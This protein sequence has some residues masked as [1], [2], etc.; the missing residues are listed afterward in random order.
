[1]EGLLRNTSELNDITT[2]KETYQSLRKE[3]LSINVALSNLLS[4]LGRQEISGVDDRF[5]EWRNSCEDIHRQMTD[6]VVRV[7]VAGAVKSGKSTLVNALFRG[8]YLKRGAGILTS[9]VTRIR[10]GKKLRAVVYFKSWE[11]VNAD[12]EQAVVMLP[13]LDRPPE[14]SFDLRLDHHRYLL[15]SAISKLGEDLQIMNG[16]RNMNVVLLSLYLAGYERVAPILSSGRLTRE[17][18]GK[19]FAEHQVF[20]GDDALAVYLKDVELEIKDSPIDRSIEIA[21]CQGSDSP[22]PLHLAMIQDY[23]LKTHFIVYVI[24]SRIGLR[25]ADIR[26]LSIIK[27]M[28]IIDNI[29]FV[30]NIDFS[31]HESAEELQALVGRVREELSILRPEP[32]IYTF[33]ALFNLFRCKSVTI[34]KKENL[35]LQQWMEEKDLVDLSGHETSRFELSLNEKLTLQRFELLLKNHLERMAVM[36]SGIEHWISMNREVLVKDAGEAAALIKKIENQQQ[37]IKEVSSLISSTLSGARDKLLKT[38]K[39][40]IDKFFSTHADG[41]MGQT[42][43]FVK[44]FNIQIEKFRPKLEVSGFSGTL[45]LVF[46]EFKRSL[47]AFIA[48]NIDPEIARFVKETEERLRKYLVS[49][50]KPYY[51]MASEEIEELKKSLGIEEEAFQSSAGKAQLHLDLDAIKQAKG[52]ALPSSAT[53]LRY[54]ARIRTEAMMKLGLYSMTKLF[55]KVLRKS[56]LGDRTDEQIKAL[57]GSIDVMKEETVEAIRFHFDNY[58]EN[59]KFQYIGKLIDESSAHLQRMLMEKYQSYFTD[60]KAL[61]KTMEQKGSKHEDMLGFIES[62]A[63]EIN[64]VKIKIEMA[65]EKFVAA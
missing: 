9:I 35:R 15:K 38:L 17:F 4:T 40:D 20:V 24:S 62:V 55:K 33:S 49:V 54:S 44:G 46:Q 30:V 16:V 25:Q 18:K 58:R 59:L 61:E 41:L 11:E 45:Y 63:S 64:R 14:K 21:D 1:M 51:A 5:A 34:G 48:E 42:L 10:S 29:L 26:F 43:S 37:K 3:L 23:L 6:E 8:D 39:A 50:A 7:A 36:T 53:A 31:E 47:D 56:A 2:K 19:Q 12:I 28:G 32:D 57:A 60:L 27:K 52:I 65:R 22:N 13:T